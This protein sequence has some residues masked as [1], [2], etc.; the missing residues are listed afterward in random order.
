MEI[1]EEQRRRA[2]ANRLAALEKRKRYAEAAA[3]TA[4]P[5]SGAST[6]PAYDTAAAAE[7]RLAKCPRIAPPA[8]QLPFVPLPPR[9]SPPPLPPTPPQP[10]VGFQVVLEV[11]G[12]DEFWVAVV[13]VE[14]RAYP[15]EAECLG[16][17]QDCLAA[18]SVVQ[19]S[20][21]QSLSQSTHLRPV[22]KLVDYGVVLKCLKKLPGASVQEIPSS[23]KRIIQNI[24]RYHVQKWASDEEVHELLKKLPQQIKDALLP[25]QLEGVMFGLRRRGRCL[26]A[27][28]MGLGKTLQ[29]IAIACCFKDE[30]SILIVCPAVLRYSW[31]EELE[32]WDPSFMPKDIHIVF[33]RQDSLE[34][35]NATPRA[36]IISY[37]MLSRLRESMV[38]RTWAL[39]IVDESHNIRCTKKLEEKYE[40]KA[41]L[42]LASKTERIIL[43]SGTPSFSRPFDIYHQINMLWP[44]MLG[45]DKFDYA[46][47]YCLLHVARSYQGKMFKD[48]SKGTRLTE[49]NV[50]LSQTVMIR[51]LKEHLLNE[52]PPKRR[53]IIRLKLKAPDI[54][55]ATSSCGKRVNPNSCNGTLTIELPSKSNDD[56]NTKEEEDDCKKSPR[57]LTPQEIGIAKLS[58]FSEWFSNH[59]I[60]NGF[61]ANHN[62]DP[63][64]SCQ[65]TI[66][67]A[68]HLK[69]LDGIQVFISENEIRFVRIDGSTLQ[70]ER[71][72]AVDSFRLDPEVKVAIIGITAGGVGLDFSSAQNVIFV[73]L[74]KSASELLQAEDRAH[75]RG[76][77][78]AVNI[79]IFCGKNTLDESHW[80][81]LN[82]SLFRVSSLMNGKKDAVREIEVDQVCQL[83]EIKDTEETQRKLHPLENHNADLTHVP[84]KLLESDDLSIDGFL[85]IEDLEFD[86]DFTIRTIPLEFEDENPG[87]S[88]KNNPTPTVLE[89]RSC[90]DVS[91]SPAAVFCS[92]LS[93][94]KSIKRLSGNSGSLSQAASVPDFPIQVESLRF[95]VSRHTGRIHLY[96]C[97]PGHDS[98]PKPLCEN[99]LPEELN[100]PLCSPSDV[101]TRTLLLKKIP[102]FCNVF[103]AFI[104]EWLALRPIDQ[105][106]LLGKPLQLPLNLELCFLKDSINHSTEGILKGG[107]KRRAASLNDVSNP[108]PENAEWRQVVLRN[109]TCKERQYT[110]GWTIDDEPLCKLCQGLCNGRLAKSPEYFEDLFCSLACF[111]EYRLRTS[112]RA[113]RQALFQIERGKCSQCKLDCCKLVKHIKLLPLGK[114]EEYIRKVAPNIASRKKLLDKLVR[115]PIDG[116]AWHADHIIPVYKGGGECK[117]ENMRTLCVACHYEVTRTQHKELKE[118]RKKAKEHL[119]NAL[120]KQKDKPSE[121]T[122]ELDDESLLIAVPGSAYSL[123]FPGNGSDEKAAE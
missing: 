61:D 105:N 20:A 37:Q 100:S 49:L 26:I 11:C 102:S 92:V 107:S 29:A 10:P 8:R 94:C 114:R 38:N 115:E 23:T 19:Y 30:G 32:R 40:T 98:R 73:E 3:A 84:K 111:Q 39:M 1:T 109:G 41:V 88:L 60:M 119:K 7:W 104:K 96:S 55:A 46:K 113:L 118:I 71:K 4:F 122:E 90:I 74:P 117:L 103:N 22:F 5:T 123:G 67:F 112:G 79:Y 47:K 6:F 21:T 80:L 121:A 53:Q 81:Q 116:N 66:I 85:G 2:E 52:L 12:P 28:E 95:E 54:R 45:T 77:R 78:N 65:K 34:H 106:K 42:H 18:A 33:G 70:R 25:F 43:L 76:Q 9:P 69:V 101:K 14:G 99:F 83:E 44:H 110:Q 36:V 75:R 108:L 35:L 68:H 62:L 72:E 15:G 82:Q 24:P 87:T 17:V 89:D 97:V 91:L 63:Q 120:N 51:R 56:E 86:L 13:P 48:F 50:L 57:S 93:S 31:A 59:F 58:G 27:D 16:A 64:S